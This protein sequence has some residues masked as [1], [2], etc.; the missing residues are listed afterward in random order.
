LSSIFDLRF[1]DSATTACSVLVVLGSLAFV[2][3]VP[4]F[5]TLPAMASLSRRCVALRPSVS[6]DSGSILIRRC[7]ANRLSPPRHSSRHCEGRKHGP[8]LL[9]GQPVCVHVG[10]SN[11]DR[12]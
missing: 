6:C 9:P 7:P 1:C 5:F 4:R 12:R 2:P 11:M 8:F 10:L 3:L